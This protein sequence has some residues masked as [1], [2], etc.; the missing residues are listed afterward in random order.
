MQKRKISFKK[1]AAQREFERRNKSQSQY[2]K[3]KSNSNNK[4]ESQNN[5]EETPKI[6]YFQK[7]TAEKQS[8]QNKTEEKP[9]FQKRTFERPAQQHFSHTTKPAQRYQE[10]DMSRFNHPA[11]QKPVIQHNSFDDDIP[12]SAVP[13]ARKGKAFFE[14]RYQK[15]GGNCNPVS[16]RAT[17]RL[18]SLL[19]NEQ[20]ILARLKAI[21]V[22]LEKIPFAKQGYWVSSKFSLGAIQEH[23]L[24]YY[25]VQEAA[26]QLP[27]QVLNPQ[28]GELVLDACASPGGKTTQLSEWMHCEGTI[29]SLER[30]EHRM[31]ALLHNLERMRVK[32]VV[33]YEY[34]SAEA[35][36]LGLEFDKVL[37]DAPCSGNYADDPVW[38]EKRDMT[39]VLTSVGIQRR[40]LG[41]IIK[42]VKHGGILVYST[43]SLEPEENEL[44][45]QW[46][47]ERGGIVIEPSGLSVGDP[48]LTTVFGR[49][50]HASIA[51]CRRLWP[52]S[53]GTQGFFVAR[54]RRL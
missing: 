37:L 17:I 41:E 12:V 24:G 49:K 44:N 35:A 38:F 29:V 6:P 43:C 7:N 18:N 42:L 22:T 15:L 25:Y 48:G 26:A 14:E 16:L 39:G 34:D 46:L 27:V 9:H 52:H 40:L 50:L 10:Q 11:R 54:I 4:F 19:G 1:E 31:P 45:M 2:S 8:F 36:R 23:F 28:P 53:S 5:F 30:K 13:D 20:K 3:A 32:N 21:G 51:N 33:A 47:L